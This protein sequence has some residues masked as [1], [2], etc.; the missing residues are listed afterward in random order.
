MFGFFSALS[1]Q[2]AMNTG[3]EM[4]T[5]EAALQIVHQV[6]EYKPKQLTRNNMAA[7]VVG[8]LCTLCAEPIPEDWDD[9]QQL[10]AQKFASQVITCISHCFLNSLSPPNPDFRSRVLSCVYSQLTFHVR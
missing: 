3:H 4:G 6:A 1:S 10:P 5:R 2:V 7:Q 8:A 9:A